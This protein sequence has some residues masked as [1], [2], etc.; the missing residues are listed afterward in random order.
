MLFR[1]QVLI[2]TDTKK[3]A[4]A[5]MK[6]PPATTSLPL[7]GFHS[8]AQTTSI[9]RS[10]LLYSPSGALTPPPPPAESPFGCHGGCVEDRGPQPAPPWEQ[11]AATPTPG[12]EPSSAGLPLSAA[13][14]ICP[15]PGKEATGDYFCYPL[16]PDRQTRKPLR[17]PQ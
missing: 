6:P 5:T 13:S 17:D 2:Y 15:L 4:Q 9:S 16:V 14:L 8:A 10:P 12:R 11:G 1:F 3:L 7:P